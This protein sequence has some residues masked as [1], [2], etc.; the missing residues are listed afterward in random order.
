MDRKQIRI[1]FLYEYKLG[2]K[3]AEATRNINRAFGRNTVNE[4]TVHRWFRKFRNGDESLKEEKGRGRHSVVDNDRLKKLVEA[5]PDTSARQLALVVGVSHSTV[6]H[7]LKKLGKSKRF[8][9]WVTDESNEDQRNRHRHP[10][11]SE[12]SSAILLRN[13]NHVAKRRKMDYL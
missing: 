10:R 7:H 6:I 2:H 12:G 13:K 1:I 9:R 5:E 11:C 8:D 3:A 4:R